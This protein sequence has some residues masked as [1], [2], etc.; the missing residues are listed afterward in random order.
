[1]EQLE[2]KYHE[3]EDDQCCKDK[4]EQ[5]EYLKA[6]DFDDQL[7]SNIR[8]Y[9]CCRAK[10]GRWNHRLQKRKSCGYAFMSKMWTRAKGKSKRRRWKYKCRVDWQ[11][12][13]D[14]LKARPDNQCLKQ[15]IDNLH[16]SFG[17]KWPHLR[18]VATLC[19]GRRAP[20]WWSS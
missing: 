8:I 20:A 4:G 1:M 2:D 13:K 15:W 11:A 19:L 14:A 17:N 16:Q 5:Q 7:C 3:A 18:C 12:L 6:L 9:N 10:T